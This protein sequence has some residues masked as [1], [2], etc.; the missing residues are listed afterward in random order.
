[1]NFK[2]LIVEL[3]IIYVLNTHVK[4]RSNQILFTIQSINF[5]LIFYA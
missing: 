2:N 4:F 3:Y 5:K 1:M